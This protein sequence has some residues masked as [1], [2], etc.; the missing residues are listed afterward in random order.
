MSTNHFLSPLTPPLTLYL[1]P[2]H[3]SPRGINTP[4]SKSTI[5][6][7]VAFIAAI[8]GVLLVAAVNVA[9]P[10]VMVSDPHGNGSFLGL[11]EYNI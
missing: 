2:S 8:A 3:A 10:D 4:I 7:R 5:P 1:R 9:W 11:P 6:A